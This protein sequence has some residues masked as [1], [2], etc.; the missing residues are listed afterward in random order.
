MRREGLSQR[1]IALNIC[2]HYSTVSRELKISIKPKTEDLQ[3]SICR[4]RSEEMPSG[5]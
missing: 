5:Y 4:E 1:A 3:R 2:V